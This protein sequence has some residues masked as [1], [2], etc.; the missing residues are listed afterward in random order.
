MSDFIKFDASE[1][2][3]EM[4]LIREELKAIRATIAERLPLGATLLPDDHTAMRVLTM[5]QVLGVVPV[6]QS[7]IKTLVRSGKFPKPV[8]ISRGRQGFVEKEVKDWLYQRRL[9]GVGNMDGEA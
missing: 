4:R 7:H 8:Q 5:Q 1:L 3:K 6:S 9:N 2:G